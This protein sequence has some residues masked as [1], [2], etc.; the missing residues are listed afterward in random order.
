MALHKLHIINKDGEPLPE[1]REI[2]LEEWISIPDNPR[3]RDTERHAK[4]AYRHLREWQ[5]THNLVSYAETGAGDRWKADGHTRC[6]LWAHGHDEDVNMPIPQPSRIFADVYR[7]KNRAEA[8]RLYLNFDG[9]GPVDTTIDEVH[10]A[11]RAMGFEPVSPLLKSRKFGGALKYL[12]RIFNPSTE[13]RRHPEFT[14]RVVGEFIDQ[15]KL[16]DKCNPT[17]VMF[18]TGV[19]MGAILTLRKRGDRFVDFWARYA[20]GEGNKIGREMDAV[21]AL[22]HFVEKRRSQKNLSAGGEIMY[23]LFNRSVKAAEDDIAGKTFKRGLQEM[24]PRAMQ[25]YLATTPSL[26]KTDG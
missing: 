11:L 20:T 16:L 10:G 26:S 21:E 4:K 19:T 23:D 8:E 14:Y 17:Q 24:T 3:Q 13:A 7:V 15:I 1:R 22:A 25:E 5:P 2:D 9:K 18:P 12:F 6:Y